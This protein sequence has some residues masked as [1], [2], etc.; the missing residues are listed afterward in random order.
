MSSLVKQGLIR[1]EKEAA[2]GM[3]TSMHS[4]G[5]TDAGVAEVR[6]WV[7][8]SVVVPPILRDVLQAKLEFSREEDDLLGLIETV[9]EEEGACAS[10]YAD[11]HMN[12]MRAQQVR[13]RLRSRGRLLSFE[14]RVRDVKLADEAALWGLIAKRLAKLRES[15]EDV[16]DEIREEAVRAAGDG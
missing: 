8:E 14:D 9:R 5:A 11:A 13:R 3:P 1:L 12:D 2:A 15:L 16:L 4:Y 7:R 10:R 6:G